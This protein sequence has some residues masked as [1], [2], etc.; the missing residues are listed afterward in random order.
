MVSA[1]HPEGMTGLTASP[2][3]D[4]THLVLTDD[5]GRTYRLD[6]TADVRRMVRETRPSTHEP[7]EPEAPTLGPREIQRRIRGGLDPQDIAELTGA[8]LGQIERYAAPVMAERAYVVE[9][10][11]RLRIGH[12][13]DV[14]VL[15]ELVSHRL[16][17]RGIT[18]GVTWLSWREEGE[19]WS[20]AVDFPVSGRTTRAQWHFDPATGA[21][22]ARDDEARW[23]TETE[24][25]DAP[26]P[27]RHLSVVDEAA[28]LAESRPAPVAAA[29]QDPESATELLLTDLGER[30]GQRESADDLDL[31]GDDDLF[32]GFGPLA[33]RSG[34]DVSFVASRGEEEAGPTEESPEPPVAEDPTPTPPG[35]ESRSRRGNRAKVPSWDEIVFGA[36]TD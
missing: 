22:D 20:V 16:A 11:Q 29:P 12:Q 19:P 33:G 25:L 6:L 26:I 18:H 24:L 2:G 14:P 34:S 13:S 32:D 30:R 15:G 31:D 23:L 35:G 5:D 1:W 9:T 7:V 4:G 8:D 28:P 17:T 10:A 36:K 21:L 3:Q 27:A